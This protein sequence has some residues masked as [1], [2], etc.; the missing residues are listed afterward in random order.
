MEKSYTNESKLSIETRKKR[1]EIISRNG[2]LLSRTKL[3]RELGYAKPE[4]AERW[5]KE[6]DIL[7]VP[8][9]KRRVYE[10][11]LVAKAIVQTRGMC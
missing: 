11:A 6:H 7:P 2:A 8:R 1:D 5:A 3:A 9:G 4:S 10:A